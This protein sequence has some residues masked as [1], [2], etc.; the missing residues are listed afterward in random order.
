MTARVERHEWHNEAGVYLFCSHDA[1]GY[2]TNISAYGAWVDE[3][4]NLATQLADAQEAIRA[5]VPA[6]SPLYLD[7]PA[8]KRA[9]AAPL[10]DPQPPEP[11]TP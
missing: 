11:P 3:I 4:L 2:R 8:V 1:H 9:M 7:L 5:A 10:S 6:M